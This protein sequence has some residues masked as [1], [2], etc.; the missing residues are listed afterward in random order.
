MSRVQRSSVFPPE[1]NGNLLEDKK[2]W[3]E[4][5]AEHKWT[6]IEKFQLNKAYETMTKFQKEAA[7]NRAVATLVLYENADKGIK[8]QK[9]VD[10][11]KDKLI[12]AENEINILQNK[13]VDLGIENAKF[14]R[15][16]LFTRILYY[17]KRKNR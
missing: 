12:R 5:I 9:L 8:L 6:T 10:H 3:E 2:Y 13:C 4:V 15:P 14:K 17:F 7:I 1:N 11:L 16:S